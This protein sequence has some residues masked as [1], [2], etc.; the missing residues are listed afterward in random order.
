[1]KNLIDKCKKAIREGGI[2][3]LFERFFNIVGDYLKN[4]RI[5]FLGLVQGPVPMS[6]WRKQYPG[7]LFGHPF[8]AAPN[9]RVETLTIVY[10]VIVRN[11]YHIELIGEHD[12][13]V[14]A[15]ANIG[16]F[17]VFVASKYPGV[18]I[19]AFEPTPST[20][21]ILKEN[22]KY[23]PNIK[24]F[25]HGL[26]E[27]AEAKSIIS[28][29]HPGMNYVGDGGT[30]IEIKTIDSLGI[31]MNFLKMDTEGYEA[32][33]LKG[34]AETIKKYK[35]IIAMSAYHRPEDKTELPA[36]VNSFA[37]YTCELRH[38]CEEDLICQPL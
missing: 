13:V 18:T 16:L 4:R 31:P 22:T 19:Y 8:K 32:N 25:N 38:D 23:Y 7:E 30:P 20:F 34:A 36:L 1:M 24:V 33:I 2:S 29:K 28:G 9:N 12:V 26:G 17:S 6:Q 10:E 5:A 15:G 3:L 11:Q 37:P 14:D 21:Q 27:R 35:P